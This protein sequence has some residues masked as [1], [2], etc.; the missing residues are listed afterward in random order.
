M[1]LQLYNKEQIL[2]ACL[3]V[4]ARHRYESTTTALLAEAAGVS[5]AL[6]FHHFKSKKS[7]YLNILDHCFAK[8]R[9]EMGFDRLPEYQDFFAAKEE[10]S[11]TKFDYYM[12][13]PDVYKFVQEAFFATPNELKVEIAKKYGALITDKDRE[14]ER[15]FAKVPLRTGVDR[16]Q[17]FN[18]VMLVLDY[19]DDKYLSELAADG[20]LDETYLKSFLAERNSFLAMVRH[21]IEQ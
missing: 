1:P 17:A 15:L 6:L 16:G 11:I 7:L 14:W 8:G 2:D 3:A 4:F 5:K 9:I 21:G 10:F 13:N 19:F 12:K 18:L 20:V